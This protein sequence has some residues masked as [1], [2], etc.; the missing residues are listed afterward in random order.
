M[1]SL[2]FFLFSFLLISSARADSFGYGRIW[3]SAL[4]RYFY[5]I[6]QNTKETEPQRCFGIY[7]DLIADSV[8]KVRYALG[9]FDESYANKPG[10]LDHHYSPSLDITAFNVISDFLTRDCEPHTRQRL[11]GFSADRSRSTGVQS[12]RRNVVLFGKSVQVQIVLTQASASE[13]YR[14]NL[15]PLRQLQENLSRQSE[16]NFFAGLQDADIAIYNGHSRDGGGPDFRPPVLRTRDHH[17]DY[18]GF[19]RRARPGA[20][21]LVQALRQSAKKEQILALF[22]CY[23]NQ[24]FKTQILAA[25][26]KQKMILGNGLVPYDR[27]IYASLA[28]LEGL[29]RGQCGADLEK[30]AEFG[31]LITDGF[32]AFNL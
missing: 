19:Y 30:F 29:L 14:K 11:C 10:G 15:G 16:A 31:P 13:F 12:F 32:S 1:K 22:S 2:A 23:S 26:P 18:D 17:P 24:H 6:E 28:Y 4:N 9:Y 8:L 21:A 3:P 27:T 5:D 20:K 7:K 25:R